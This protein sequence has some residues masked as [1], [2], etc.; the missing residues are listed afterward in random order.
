MKK[1]LNYITIFLITFVLPLAVVNAAESLSIECN[2]NSVQ[3]GTQK[4]CD[5]I[6]NSDSYKITGV[7]F[8]AEA[9]GILTFNNLTA[10][11]SFGADAIN[12]NMYAGA[13]S[14]GVNSGSKVGTITV[15]VAGDAELGGEGTITLSAISNG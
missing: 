5:I 9:N 11:A 7:N 4:T 12:G 14:S 10:E 13:N 15:D 3:A 1:V 6:A 2:G 8:T